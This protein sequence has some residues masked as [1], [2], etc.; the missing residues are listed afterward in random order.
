MWFPFKTGIGSHPRL[1][2]ASTI[3]GTISLGIIRWPLS[4]AGSGRMPSSKSL[5]TRHD[6]TPS[7]SAIA[8][9]VVTGRFQWALVILRF[10]VCRENNH[11]EFVPTL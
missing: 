2:S 7:A 8:P 3:S 10:I 11:T 9:V 5:A 1:R 6:C 4:R